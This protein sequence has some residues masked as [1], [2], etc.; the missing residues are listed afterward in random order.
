MPIFRRNSKVNGINGELI[1]SV[2]WKNF[3]CAV[4]KL[5]EGHLSGENAVIYEIAFSPFF[6]G[7]SSLLVT[8]TQFCNV[9]NLPFAGVI[10]H[11]NK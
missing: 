3:I 2:I 4:N 10:P 8:K 11:N 5:T 6:S 1:R 7:L 9:S